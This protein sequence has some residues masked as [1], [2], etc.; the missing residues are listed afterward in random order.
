MREWIGEYAR[1]RLHGDKKELTTH[2][3]SVT[4]SSMRSQ[5]S[6]SHWASLSIQRGEV[7]TSSRGKLRLAS[8]RGNGPER[9]SALRWNRPFIRA[10]GFRA[11][12]GRGQSL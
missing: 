1:A 3:W 4:G 12:L 7:E 6:K 8:R 2:R 9:L 10:C 5:Q 11:T